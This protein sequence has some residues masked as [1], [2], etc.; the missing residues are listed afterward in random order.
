VPDVYQGT[1]AAVPQLVG[2]A[3]KIAALVMAVRLLGEGL[4]PLLSSW[5]SVLSVS[6]IVSVAFGNLVALAQTNF[7]RMLAYSAI[8]SAGFIL[9]GIL[10]GTP[11]GYGA[12]LFYAITYALTVIPAFGMLMVL[13]RD[14]FDPES[15]EDFKGLNVRSP[16]YA[17]MMLLVMFSMAGIP[18][19]VGFVAKLAILQEALSKGF[20]M[21]ALLAVFFSVVGAYY[22]LR[23]I[24]L[25]Y[26]DEAVENS[27]IVAGYDAR[28]ALS[29]NAILL[30]VLGMFPSGLISYCAAA[31]GV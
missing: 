30:L 10:A 25:M 6:V 22:Y 28:V 12:A 9:L 17:A 18:P 21:I 13:S 26:F 7:K 8:A 29:L 20:L 5:Q 19:L 27:P 24:K 11:R 31:V 16:W 2:S 3:P 4:A 1:P 15:L 23:I 14:G